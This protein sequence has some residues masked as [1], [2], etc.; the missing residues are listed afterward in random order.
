MAGSDT[1][2]PTGT[3]LDGVMG[4]LMWDTP[5][6]TFTFPVDLDAAGYIYQFSSEMSEDGKTVARRAFAAAE[7]ICPITLTEVA[8]DQPTSIIRIY[9]SNT[10]VSASTIGPGGDPANGRIR[11]DETWNLFSPGSRHD[12]AMWHEIGHVFGLKHPHEASGVTGFEDPLPSALN[13]RYYTIMSYRAYLNTGL[14]ADNATLTV[15]SNYHS[16]QTFSFLDI[17]SLQYMMGTATRDSGNTVHSW[18]ETTGAYLLNG[19]EQWSSASAVVNQTL[20]NYTTG[21]NRLDLSNFTTDNYCDLRQP[22]IA[23]PEYGNILFDVGGTGLRAVTGGA[24]DFTYVPFNVKVCP[25]SGWI[26]DQV[27]PGSGDN[28]IIFVAA[29]EANTLVLSGNYADYTF[30]G[31]SRDWVITKTSDSKTNDC[32]NLDFVQF[33]DQTVASGSLNSP[34]IVGGTLVWAS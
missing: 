9:V 12:Q 15:A 4:G 20:Y 30:V 33:A 6:L 21:Y 19:V 2:T 25:T 32:T 34:W 7:A 5:T 13:A 16:S 27:K 26:I 23:N 10:A 24:G 22:T 11:F 28:E 1:V 3:D 8:G 31:A 18:D 17:L 29:G 14:A